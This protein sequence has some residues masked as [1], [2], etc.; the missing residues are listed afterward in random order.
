MEATLGQAMEMMTQ[1]E[2]GN[3]RDE[4]AGQRQVS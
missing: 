4:H 2:Q 1:N 3:Q